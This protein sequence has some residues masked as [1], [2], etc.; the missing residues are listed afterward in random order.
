LNAE[1]LGLAT[2]AWFLVLGLF[3]GLRQVLEEAR[4][5]ALGALPKQGD[6]GVPGR[7][8]RSRLPRVVLELLHSI[9]TGAWLMQRAR[10]RGGRQRAKQAHRLVSGGFHL[11]RNPRGV[12]SRLSSSRER[13]VRVRVAEEYG[14]V[15]CLD[16]KFVFPVNVLVVTRALGLRSSTRD[17]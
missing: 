9:S 16:L 13:L 3:V 11:D 4:C 12:H 5:V 15:G 14:R 10:D 8:P 1:V 6:V 2:A 7:V 17:A